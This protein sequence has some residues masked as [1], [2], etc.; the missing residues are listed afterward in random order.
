VSN[1]VEWLNNFGKSK[2]DLPPE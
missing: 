2:A 1:F